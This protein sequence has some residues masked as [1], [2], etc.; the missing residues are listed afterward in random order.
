ML[1]LDTSRICPP[2]TVEQTHFRI[3]ILRKIKH[4]REFE[5]DLAQKA[6]LPMLDSPQFS[7]RIKKRV[8]GILSPLEYEPEGYW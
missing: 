8:K 6:L 7:Y 1:S 3:A 2:T 4:A 5:P